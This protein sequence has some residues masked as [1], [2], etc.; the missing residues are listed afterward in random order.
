MAENSLSLEFL[1]PIVRITWR[2]REL[3]RRGGRDG[4]KMGQAVRQ[5]MPIMHL[6]MSLEN[7]LKPRK[8]AGGHQPKYFSTIEVW[9]VGEVVTGC[10]D[11]WRTLALVELTACIIAKQHTG[12]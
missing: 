8:Y 3:E 2:D 5:T 6:C 10:F 1:L 9:S 11:P 7:V 12:S 4:A